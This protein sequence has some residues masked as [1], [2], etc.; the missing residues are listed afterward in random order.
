[1]LHMT[2]A[3]A[4][5]VAEEQVAR[6]TAHRQESPKLDRMRKALVETFTTAALI[7]D[8]EESE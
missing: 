1:M 2:K 3:E 4:T 8:W 7:E 5:A 6:I